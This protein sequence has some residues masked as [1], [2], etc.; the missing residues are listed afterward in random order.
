MVVEVV[1]DEFE[2]LVV[3]VEVADDQ[4]ATIRHPRR[5]GTQRS[6]KKRGGRTDEVV[7]VDLMWRVESLLSKLAQKVAAYGRISQ[8]G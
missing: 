5:D 8:Y 3:A 6:S 1:E 4:T 2:V 7:V